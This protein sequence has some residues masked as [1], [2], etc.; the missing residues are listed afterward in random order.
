MAYVVEHP[1]R[2]NLWARRTKTGKVILTGYVWFTFGVGKKRKVMTVR[3]S[4]NLNKSDP[5]HPDYILTDYTK[6]IKDGR[7]TGV[8]SAYKKALEQ[9]EVKIPGDRGDNQG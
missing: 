7:K 1:H 5:K 6:E 4:P 8:Y 9:R 2:G 3:I